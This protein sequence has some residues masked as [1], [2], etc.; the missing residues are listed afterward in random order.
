MSNIAMHGYKTNTEHLRLQNL[1]MKQ[2]VHTE[3]H[4]FL[5][6]SP[7]QH[8]YPA[9]KYYHKKLAALNGHKMHSFLLFQSSDDSPQVQ[10]PYM[11][12]EDNIMSSKSATTSKSQDKGRVELKLYHNSQDKHTTSQL[13]FALS[14][15]CDFLIHNNEVPYYNDQVSPILTPMKLLVM[16]RKKVRSR[17]F[18]TYRQV[19]G[20]NLIV[21]NF[22]EGFL[23]D[24]TYHTYMYQSK[25]CDLHWM[26]VEEQI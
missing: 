26:A 9:G 13:N 10:I 15:D 11:S 23:G 24:I 19:S 17:I 20:T 7:V 22:V 3:V 21:L 6:Q 1:Q 5:L 4:T 12:Q 16:K 2:S 14:P 25:F 8:L 18:A